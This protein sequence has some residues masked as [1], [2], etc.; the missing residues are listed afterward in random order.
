MFSQSLL[1][2]L[3]AL[4]SAAPSASPHGNAHSHQKHHEKRADPVLRG[5]LYGLGASTAPFAGHVDF[6]VNWA[7]APSVQTDLGIFVNQLWG[8]DDNHRIPFQSAAASGPEDEYLIGFNEPDLPAQAWILPSD[9]VSAWHYIDDYK[10]SKSAKIGTPS[11]SNSIEAPQPGL[12]QP[13]P[14]GFAWISAF[15]EQ[16]TSAGYKF[17]MLCWHWYGG[18]KNSLAQDQD[19]IQQ[20]ASQMAELASNYSI[21]VVWLTEMQRVNGDQECQFIKW[22]ESTFLA[23]NPSIR[24]YAYN[25]FAGTLNNGAGLS[26][27]GQAFIG[28]DAC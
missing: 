24:A 16:A 15:L 18:P 11:V 12:A 7:T 6:S 22:F 5:I 14:Q 28:Q 2:A 10:I 21:P 27:A 20:Q 25:Q 17:D 3:C 4:A 8:A 13:N 1:F 26:L 19:M 23:A 9:A